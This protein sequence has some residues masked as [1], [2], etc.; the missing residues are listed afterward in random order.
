MA[1]GLF[2]DA[3]T[4][5]NKGQSP[6]QTKAVVAKIVDEIRRFAGGKVAGRLID[7][8]HLSA[9]V[10]ERASLHAP[11]TLSRR[12]INERLSLELSSEEIADL[13]TNVE[14]EVTIAS[15]ELT[16]KAPFWRTDIAI[17][18][19]IVEEVG[20]LYGF[21]RLP[22]ELPGRNLTPPS[23]DGLLTLKNQIRTVLSGGGANELLTYSFVHANLLQRAGQDPA[24]A[25]ELSNALS[26]D[27]QYFRVSLLPSLLE[28]V[29]P[30]L[31]AGHKEFAIYEMGKCHNLLHPVE[32]EGL[33]GEFDM[34]SLVYA[35]G[36]GQDQAA[37]S[38]AAFYHARI[39][40]E[41]LA[42]R[43]GIS[44]VFNPIP[45]E[46]DVPI[47]K[48]YDIARSAFVQ[49]ANGTFLGV[50]GEFKTNV[51]RDLKLPVQSAGFEIGLR[52]LV[53]VS[54]QSGYKRLPRF[55]KLEQDICLKVAA[56]TPYQTV[57]DFVRTTLDELRPEHTHTSLSPVDIY[58]RGD[59]TSHKQITLRVSL[60]SYDRTL[61]DDEV[62][63]IL[64][65]IAA[66]AT[67]KLS[68]ERV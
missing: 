5:F 19:D 24:Q 52:E 11:V 59:D 67:Q 44:L 23:K 60:A 34:L 58:Q 68:A 12:F 62:A 28:K 40:L 43:L 30:N 50:V 21:D 10:M 3:V 61:T 66:A 7:D 51:R 37:G 45:E 49:T 47:M 1:H 9:D 33:P 39:Y 57:Y 46:T 64:D 13:L 25:F 38:G 31:R 18:E 16:A 27:V 41:Y 26:P 54:V 8:N 53:S 42:E 35:A 4:R 2:T 22:L 15:D 48:P 63:K 36:D 17:P 65:Q 55:P 14:F 32:D 29:Y 6:L 56:D 20:R